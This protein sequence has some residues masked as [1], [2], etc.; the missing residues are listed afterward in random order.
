MK[1]DYEAQFLIIL[2]LKDKIKK[3]DEKKNTKKL[4]L[5]RQTHNLSNEID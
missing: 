5:T 4:G 3:I 1:A 2:I